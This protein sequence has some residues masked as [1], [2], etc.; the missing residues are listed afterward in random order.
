MDFRLSKNENLENYTYYNSIIE[1]N[2]SNFEID[3]FTTFFIINI[4]HINFL[5]N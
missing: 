1:D 5:I 3:S 2:N 4:I